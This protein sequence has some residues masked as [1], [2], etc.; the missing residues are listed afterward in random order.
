[1]VE[2]FPFELPYVRWAD[3]VLIHAG[4]NGAWQRRLYD[5]EFVYVLEGQG[6]IVLDGRAHFAGADSLFLVQPRVWHSFLADA[7]VP[8][9]LL[10]VHFDWQH[11]PDTERFAHFFSVSGP[12]EPD[13]YRAPVDVPHWNPR[14][15]PFLD[16]RGRGR[17]RRALE[18]LCLEHGRGD[19]EA[20]PISGALLA[21]AVGQ[22]AREA[23]LLEELGAHPSVGPD[24]VRRVQRARD[25][26]EAPHE[27][28]LSIEAAAEMV[29]WSGDHMR[30]MF[31]QVLGSSPAQI[32]M[33]ARLRRAQELLRYGGL[34]IA[35]VA[36]RCAFEDASHFARV[37]RRATGLT[38]REW[39]FNNRAP[40]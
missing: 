36:R 40:R 16:L 38:P 22:M 8:W 33:G 7:G 1:M 15:R 20:T 27:T 39:V 23:R 21:A 5:H 26:L 4:G 24:A 10:G 30:R 12:E 11:R 37:F 2:T 31:K 25:L 13:L 34:P 29:G 17:V 3:S 35:E 9:R 18:A 6:H 28:P 19:P 14:V 32:Q